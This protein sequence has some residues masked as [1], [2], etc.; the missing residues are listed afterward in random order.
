MAPVEIC[1]I[2]ISRGHN[3]VGHHGC[4]P[5]DFPMIEVPAVECVAS[6][7]LREDRYFDFKE[8]YKG[9][10][11]FFSLEVF[12]ELCDALEVEGIVPS[13]VRRNVFTRNVDLNEL[14]GQDFEVQGVH[15]HGTEESRPCDWMNRAIAPGAREFL[16]GRGGL[17]ARILTDG[18][19]RSG[20]RVPEIVR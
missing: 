16:K 14:I 5:D 3:F 9:Q 1:H 15:F 10:I 12:D 6:R 2:Y 19:L 18:T 17:R 13:A 8:D 11:T 7:G 4:E 20:A